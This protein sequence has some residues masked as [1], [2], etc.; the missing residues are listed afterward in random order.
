MG[1][2]EIFYVFLCCDF[3]LGMHIGIGIVTKRSEKLNSN[4]VQYSI[5]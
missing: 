1:S 4:R 5:E 2:R 3:L